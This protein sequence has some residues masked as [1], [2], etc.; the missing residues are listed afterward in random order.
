MLRPV[1]LVPLILTALP[2]QAMLP[3]CAYDDMIRA[4]EG[5]VQIDRI[6]VTK[7]EDLPET[8]WISGTVAAVIAGPMAVGDSLRVSMS[9]DPAEAIPGA[10]F[11]ADSAALA[12]VPVL[13]IHYAG[14]AVAAYGAGLVALDAVTGTTAYRFSCDEAGNYLPPPDADAA[15]P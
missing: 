6:A 9:C 1:A 2:A 8:C 4:A 14:D 11:Y 10:D 5:V 12:Q 3:P 7:A 15:A 13:E